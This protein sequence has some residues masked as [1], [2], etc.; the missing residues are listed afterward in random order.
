MSV[1]PGETVVTDTSPAS[2][3][4]YYYYRCCFYSYY[5]S[6]LLTLL[7]DVALRSPFALR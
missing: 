1:G 5:S 2:H 4:N 7:S 3:F 6:F